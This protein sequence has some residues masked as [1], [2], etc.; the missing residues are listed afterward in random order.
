MGKRLVDNKLLDFKDEFNRFANKDDVSVNEN[1]I[2]KLMKKVTVLKELLSEVYKNN[3]NVHGQTTE[4]Q[5]S[6]RNN[7][8]L[9]TSFV[10]VA[11]GIVY[12]LCKVV[13]NEISKDLRHRLQ[14]QADDQRKKNENIK[15]AN[16]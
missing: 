15:A 13:K 14:R 1:N 9:V 7:G 11:C 8:I 3:D 6:Y 16:A 10:T 5:H 4:F 2:I 12:F